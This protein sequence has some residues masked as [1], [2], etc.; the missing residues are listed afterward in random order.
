MEDIPYKPMGT[1]TMG[2]KTAVSFANI[3]MAKIETEILSK[4]VSNPTVWKHFIDDVFSLWDI[5]KPDI[6]IRGWKRNN[7]ISLIH[8]SI[9]F[10]LSCSLFIIILSR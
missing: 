8:Y 5:S 7:W 2:T 6:E 4:V 3:F 10:F 9:H 1:T